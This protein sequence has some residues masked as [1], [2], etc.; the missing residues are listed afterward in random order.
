MAWPNATIVATDISR[1]ALA[2]AAE[3]IADYGL[4]DRITLR[5]GDVFAALDPNPEEGQ[6]A[7]PGG[8]DLILSNPPYVNRRSMAALPSEFR[9]EPALALDGGPQGMDIVARI[10]SSYA[11]WLKP[12]GLLAVEIGHEY[13]ACADLFAQNFPTLTPVWLDT[14][15]TSQ[16]VFLLGAV[17]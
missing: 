12:D 17:R 11:S 13:A 6:E 10:V 3:N 16:R 1:Q 9:H 2:L 14:A 8:F 4:S 5:T 15:Q 7:D